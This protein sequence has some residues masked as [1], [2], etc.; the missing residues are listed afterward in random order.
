MKSWFLLPAATASGLLALVALVMSGLADGEWLAWLGAGL[1]CLPLPLFV[2][3]TRLGRVVRTSENLPFLLLVSAAGLLLAAWEA[4]MERQAG[5]QPVAIALLGTLLLTAY[6]FWYSRFG[7]FASP[8]LAVGGKMP[9]FDLADLDGAA[10]RAADFRGKPAIFLF[11][12]GNEC[13]FCVAQVQEIAARHPELAAL[14]VRLALVSP[15]SADRTRRLATQVGLSAP[16]HVDRGNAAARELGIAREG[17]VMP[18]VVVTNANATI[19]YSDQTDNYRV[20]PEPDIYISILKR[21]G[22][23]GRPGGR[24]EVT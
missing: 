1:A 21:T 12:S 2:V 4:W 10:V 20:R 13:P 19:L 6:V 3:R 18:T 16:F 11:F 22:A 9:E 8:K 17:S 24:Q 5:W 14:D 23:I 15:Q 7:R